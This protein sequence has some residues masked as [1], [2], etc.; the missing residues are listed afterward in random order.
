MSARNGCNKTG[1]K[2]LI[3]PHKNEKR[4]GI[5]V[6]R[7][8][9]LAETEGGTDLESM[10]FSTWNLAVMPTKLPTN[11]KSPQPEGQGHAGHD[12]ALSIFRETPTLL[13]CLKD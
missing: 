3:L 4:R 6:I 12:S 5:E 8:P 10:R 9:C 11:D 1:A 7:A 2:P 13:P